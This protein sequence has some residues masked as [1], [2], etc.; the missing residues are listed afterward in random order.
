MMDLTTGFGS[1]CC[2][3]S[4]AWADNK[5]LPERQ[6]MPAKEMRSRTVRYAHILLTTMV[7]AGCLGGGRV[8]RRLCL[9]SR[10]IDF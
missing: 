9:K 2:I 5:M 8:W 4:S 10:I 6:V 3:V 1:R 7:V